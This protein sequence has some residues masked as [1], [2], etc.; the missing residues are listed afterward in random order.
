MS[1]IGLRCR[2]GTVAGR[3]TEDSPTS[4][5]HFV[6]SCEDCRAYAHYLERARD[7]LDAYGGTAIY[8]V[9][10]AQM[11][12][13]DGGE[14]L[15]CLRL[16]PRGLMRWYVDCCHTP[17]GN[18]F[19]SPSMPFVGLPVDFIDLPDGRA[20]RRTF[21]GPVAAR[22]H[23]E[24][25]RERGPAEPSWL[26]KIGVAGRSAKLVVAGWLRGQARPSPFFDAHTGAPRVAPYVLEPRERA[27][28][29]RRLNARIEAERGG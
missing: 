21:L 12:I 28:L 27:A 14:Q 19:D 20:E 5:L 6:C 7:V 26:E 24:F 23:D 15:R 2:C 18:T 29:Y 10:P 9:T 8:Q 17:V 22:V 3:L 13:T 11:T 25:D 1:Q 16:T 4:G